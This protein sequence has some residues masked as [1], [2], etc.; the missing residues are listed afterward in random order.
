MASKQAKVVVVGAGNVGATYANDLM[1]SGLAKEIVLVDANPKKAEGEAMDLN[2]GAS[3][4]PPCKVSY[5]GY[6]E[7][8]DADLV[9]LTAGAAQKPGET[10]LDLAQK[11][12]DLYREIIPQVTG[13]TTEAI[14]LVVA[15]PVDV[16]TYATLKVSGYPENRVIGSGTLLDTS[17]FRYLVGKHCGVDPRNVHGYIIGE[18][19]DTEVPL[20]SSLTIGGVYLEKYCLACERECNPQKQLDEIFTQVKNAAYKIIECKGSTY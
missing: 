20:F 4:L 18:H 19:G 2:H 9:V 12:T 1:I 10:R 11:N 5:G 8:V 7:C 13:H 3:F 14:L 17:R 15:N 16:L 6:E